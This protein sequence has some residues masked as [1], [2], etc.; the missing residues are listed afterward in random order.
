[1]NSAI[2]DHFNELLKRREA[3]SST[4]IRPGL[5]IPH[6]VVE[7]KD[8]RRDGLLGIQSRF[9]GG[10]YNV[11]LR[12]NHG[13]VMSDYYT[14]NSSNVFL[15]E[16]AAGDPPGQAAGASGGKRPD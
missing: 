15:L 13:I 6:I 11:V 10:N 12:D 1:M 5:A 2:A 7:G 14:E 16:G 9:S 4:V 3:E 8:K